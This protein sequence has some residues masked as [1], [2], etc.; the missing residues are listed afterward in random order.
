MSLELD[1][2]RSV[3][4]AANQHQTVMKAPPTRVV[5]NNWNR[6]LQKPDTIEDMA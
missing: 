2:I 6:L 1:N 4:V 3:F 5:I